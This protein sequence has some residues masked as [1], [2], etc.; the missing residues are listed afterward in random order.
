MSD[1][2]DAGTAR[3]VEIKVSDDAAARLQSVLGGYEN[4]VAGI[5]LAVAGRGPAGFQHALSIIEPGEEPEGDTV[6]ESAGLTFFVEGRNAQYLDG[7]VIEFDGGEGGMLQFENPNPIWLDE[8]SK[9]LQEL[10]DTQINPQIA[11]HGGSVAL[12]EV[13]VP[14]A[15]IELGGGCVGCG[16]V[17]VTLK[18]GIEVAMKELIP[19][20]TEVID[21][22]NHGSGD[23]PYYKPSKK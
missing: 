21:Q 6:V 4:P 14:K 11:S 2:A 17:D 7:I 19:E 9:Q 22:T 5:R 13:D 20:I 12:L 1:E 3:S 18:Q 15:Y 23:N 8:V 10:F 16:M